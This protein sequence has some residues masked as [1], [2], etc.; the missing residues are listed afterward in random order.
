M[1]NLLWCW[2]H[3]GMLD[4]GLE[5]SFDGMVSASKMDRWSR[6]SQLNCIPKDFNKVT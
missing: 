3:G 5:L 6:R 2:R 1:V 4:C